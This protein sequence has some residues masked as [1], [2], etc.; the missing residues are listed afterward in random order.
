[1]QKPSPRLTEKEIH[2]AVVQAWGLMGTPGSLVAT[3]PNARA[4]GQPGLTK[5]LP[6]LLVIRPDNGVA[7]LELKTHKGTLSKDQI[8]VLELLEASGTVVEVTYGLDE[9]Y[10]QLIEW[11]VVRPFN[12]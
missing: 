11:G 4:F 9:A 10:R 1:M 6:D 3:I 12:W 5:G 8:L 2:T 7:F